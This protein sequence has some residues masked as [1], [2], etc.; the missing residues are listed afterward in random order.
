MGSL[1]M[2]LELCHNSHEETYIM[3][4]SEV[5]NKNPRIEN[6]TTCDENS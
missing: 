2:E 6:S 5:A 1:V 3:L 4:S